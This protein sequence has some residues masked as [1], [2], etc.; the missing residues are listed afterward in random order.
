MPHSVCIQIL[1][2]RIAARLENFRRECLGA[3]RITVTLTTNSVVEMLQQLEGCG[4]DVL[5]VRNRWTIQ[6]RF[7]D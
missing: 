6:T 4:I 5:Q 7:G 2:A 1:R 3:A